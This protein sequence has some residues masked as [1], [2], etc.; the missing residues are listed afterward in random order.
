MTLIRAQDI[1]TGSR[2]ANVPT[3]RYTV[4]TQRFWTVLINYELSCQIV[5]M[6]ISIVEDESKAADILETLL[7]RHVTDI[8]S[9]QVFTKPLEAVEGIKGQNPD[10]VFLDINMPQLNG[11]ELLE[12]LKEQSFEVIF[13]TAHDQFAIQAIKANALDY[14]LK[15][16][17]EREL[18]EAVN[19]FRLNDRPPGKSHLPNLIEELSTRNPERARICFVGKNRTSFYDIAEILRCEASGNYTHFYFRDG[20]KLL[21][22][23]TLKS[24]EQLLTSCGFVRIHKSHLV[25]PDCIRVLMGRNK[26][27]MTD[28]AV[29]PVAR[30]RRSELAHLISALEP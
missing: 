23:Q 30:R 20:S 14:L 10:L 24:Y 7:R 19:K 27:E 22:S 17:S 21:S 15:P 29:V 28:G 8:E 3:E 2:N 12:L 11:F 5:V 1:G 9:L 6:K 4:S 26:L 25:N 16:V 13:V 18:V